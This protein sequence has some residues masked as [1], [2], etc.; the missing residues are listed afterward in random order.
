MAMGNIFG[1]ITVCIR[2]ISSRESGMAMAS[3]RI[4]TKFIRDTI[5][6]TRRRDLEST[7][8]KGSK[9]TKESFGTTLDKATASSLLLSRNMK[10]SNT[11]G[12][13]SK[14]KKTRMER[15]KSKL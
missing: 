2:G 6:W 5:G 3:G 9:S 8:G 7:R 14:A 10:N 11:R 15:L 12:A 13:G 4:K 1:L